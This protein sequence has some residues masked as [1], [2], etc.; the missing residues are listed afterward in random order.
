MHCKADC[1]YRE[2]ERRGLDMVMRCLTGEE[3]NDSEMDRESLPERGLIKEGAF[4]KSLKNLMRL[5]LPA[6]QSIE[7]PAN[8][9]LG[10]ENCC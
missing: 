8:S 10:G 9:I 4:V 5:S 1:C 6:S 3:N 7:R 2:R